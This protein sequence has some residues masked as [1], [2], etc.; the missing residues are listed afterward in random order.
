MNAYQWIQTEDGSPSLVHPETG[1]AMHSRAGAFAETRHVY[2]PAMKVAV[3]RGWPLRVLTVGLGLGYCEFHALGFARAAGVRI[4]IDSY[5]T[6]P[7][8][9]AYLQD[10]CLGEATADPAHA[11]AYDQIAALTED[12]LMMPRETLR[13]DMSAALNKDGWRLHGALTVDTPVDP[14]PT[15]I[16]FDAFSKQTSPDL[17]RAEL[18][19]PVLAGAAPECALATYAATGDLRRALTR[20]GFDVERR[21]GFAGKRHCTLAVRG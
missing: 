16:L 8:L 10:W 11:G 14:P 13:P 2:L 21:E 9:R 6:D 17:W 18:L 15:V 20:H 5:E 3:D 4:E 1:E 7:G 12:A 19:D